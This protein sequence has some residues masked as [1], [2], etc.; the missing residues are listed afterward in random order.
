MKI[1]YNL[2]NNNKLGQSCL[3]YSFYKQ[4]PEFEKNILLPKLITNQQQITPMILKL[5]KSRDDL[6]KQVIAQLDPA[7]SLTILE[8][9][10]DDP[11]NYPEVN[12]FILRKHYISIVKEYN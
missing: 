10:N 5:L 6:K 3:Y 2:V 8:N 12:N 4:V 9:L 11:R 1:L 7:R